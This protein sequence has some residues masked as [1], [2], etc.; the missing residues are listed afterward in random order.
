MIVCKNCGSKKVVKFGTYKLVQ[1]Y[2]CKTCKRK[3]KADDSLFHSKVAANNISSALTMYYCDESIDDIRSYLRDVQDYYPSK[4]VVAHWIRKYAE[5][6]YRKLRSYR[7]V[8]GNKWIINENE[9][10][11]NRQK[12]WIFTVI[13]IETEFFLSLRVSESRTSHDLQIV[14]QKAVEFSGKVPLVMATDKL[15]DLLKDIR[16]VDYYGRTC[17]IDKIGR[18]PPQAVRFKDV[19]E[20]LNQR[21]LRRNFKSVKSLTIFMNRL[22][23]HHNFFSQYDSIK[24]KTPAQ[25]AGILYPYRS[26]ADVIR[27]PTSKYAELR[28]HNKIKNHEI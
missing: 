7:P 2:W 1:R 26:W 11:F 4:S 23:I 24:G 8:V 12:I 14:L 15:V 16:F 19:K 27:Q 13:D 6:A 9:L 10:T 22:L 3:F 21:I 17:T 18:L 28:S 20:D 5:V 25:A